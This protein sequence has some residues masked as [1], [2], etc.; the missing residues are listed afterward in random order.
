MREASL[1]SMHLY[2]LVWSEHRILGVKNPATE[3]SIH[4]ETLSGAVETTW[5]GS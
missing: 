1:R 4:L 3:L 5:V 2:L